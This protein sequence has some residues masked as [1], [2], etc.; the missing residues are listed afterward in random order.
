MPCGKKLN[1]QNFA[2]RQLEGNYGS[3]GGLVCKQ[4]T[5]KNEA[6]EKQKNAHNAMWKKN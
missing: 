6:T 4:C 1:T 3:S 2:A 5:K